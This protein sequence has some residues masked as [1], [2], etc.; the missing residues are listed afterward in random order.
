[1]VCGCSLRMNFDSCCGSARSNPVNAIVDSNDLITRS[2]TRRAMSGPSVFTSSFCAYSTPP[3]ERYS[4]AFHMWWNSSRT[5]EPMSGLTAPIVATSRA[6]SS[7]SSSFRN[8]NSWLAASSP[9]TS[10]RIA[11]LRMPE[12]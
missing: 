6:I 3:A 9:R 10:V 2:S 12:T 7:I 1:M 11:A 5:T 4:A 8:L